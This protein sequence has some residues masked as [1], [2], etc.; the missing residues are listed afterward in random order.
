M[1]GHYADKDLF[2]EF[3]EWIQERVGTGEAPPAHATDGR[4]G[5]TFPSLESKRNMNPVEFDEF[6]LPPMEPDMGLDFGDL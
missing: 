6:G 5:V 2:D 3:L 4:K 1:P